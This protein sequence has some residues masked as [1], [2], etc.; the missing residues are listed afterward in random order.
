MKYRTHRGN[1]QK[2]VSTRENVHEFIRVIYNVYFSRLDI[3]RLQAIATEVGVR[4]VEDYLVHALQFGR[5]IIVL[6]D[7]VT[8]VVY[9]NKLDYILDYKTLKVLHVRPHIGG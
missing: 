3:E 1:Y 7:D 8:L 2:V 4:D 6:R 9:C 5:C